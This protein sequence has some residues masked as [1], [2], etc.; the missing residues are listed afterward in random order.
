MDEAS[1]LPEYQVPFEPD[2]YDR[3]IEPLP[4]SREQTFHLPA[5]STYGIPRKVKAIPLKQSS[6]TGLEMK[7]SSIPELPRGSVAK[8]L[9]GHRLEQ[10]RQQLHRHAQNRQQTYK[11]ELKDKNEVLF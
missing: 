10:H 11:K 3:M 4:S 7:H 5:E 1:R 6:T 2:E 9:P 8:G